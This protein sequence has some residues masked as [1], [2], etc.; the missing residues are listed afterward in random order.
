M[1]NIG[2]LSPGA[3]EY[4]VGEVASSAEDYYAGRGELPGRWVGSLAVELGLSGE[5]D[6]DDF[7]RVLSGQ[8]PGNGVYLTTARGSAARAAVRDERAPVRGELPQFVDTDR[9]AVHLGVSVRYVRQ[10]LVNGE[11]YRTRV[12][13]A[14]DGEPVGVPPAYLLGVKAVGNGQA[15]SD[16]WSVSRGELERFS[17]SRRKV[18]ARPGYDLTLR[19]PKSVSVLWALADDPLRAQ[20]R[21]AHSEAVDEVVRYYET[22]AVFARKGGREQRLVR[23]AGIVA[24][25]FDHRTS[26]AGDP[27]LHT[28][29]VTANMTSV[30]DRDGSWRAIAGKGLYEHAKAAGCLYQAHLR[31]LLGERLGVQFEPVVNGHAEARGVPRAVIDAFSKRRAEITELLAESGNRSAKAA[32][33]ATL[34]TRRAKDYDVDA[35]TLTERWTD[36]ANEFGFGVEQV[37]ACFG[38]DCQR[39]P[40]PASIEAFFEALAGA[41]GMTERSS[42]FR[43]TDV[44]EVCASA[45]GAS[46]TAA[47]LEGIADRFLASDRVLLVDRP[48]RTGR[49]AWNLA[50]TPAERAT[51]ET[52][53][54]QSLDKAVARSVVS[55]SATQRLYTVSALVELEAR[56]LAAANPAERTATALRQ[57]VVDGVISQ[58]GELSGEQQ[59]MVRA[60]CGSGEFIQPV[61]GR[62]GAGKTYALEAV[63]AAHVD[64]GVPILGCAV[65]ATAAAELERQAGFA[66]STGAQAG[67]VARLLLDLS[68]HHSRGLATGTVVVVDEASMLGT[69]DLAR[70]VD[71]V[72]KAG[73]AVR[74][75]G[76]PDQHGSVDVGGVFRRL[77]AD[78]GDRL[79]RL[80]EN[81]RQ[82][83]HGERLA[84]AEYRDGHI[85]DALAR[86]DDADQIVRSPTAGASLDAMTADWYAARLSGHAEPMIAGP[87]SPRQALN[88]RARTLLKANGELTGAPLV[89]AG[90]EFMVGDEV[91][92]RRN[93]RRLNDPNGRG[94]V[95]NGSTGTITGI[96]H[97]RREV[98]VAFEPEGTI[99]IPNEYLSAGRLEQGYARTTYGVQGATHDVV[100]YQPTD[101]SSFEEGYV[102]LTRGRQQTRVYIVDGVQA[103]VDNDEVAHAATEPRQRGIADIAQAL[104]RRRSGHMAAD[105]APDLDAVAQTLAGASLSQLAAR[106]RHLDQLIR[107]APADMSPAIERAQQTIASIRTRQRAWDDVLRAAKAEAPV[108][109]G[110]PVGRD[111]DRAHAALEG[112][113]RAHANMVGR[114]EKAETRQAQRAEW[115]AIHA[116]LIDA[117]ELVTRAET[118][119]EIQVRVA[120]VNNPDP[121]VRDLIGPEP[122]NQRERLAW[123][124]AVEAAAV[125]SA[126]YP[127][128]AGLTSRSAHE[129]LLGAR[130]TTRE[131]GDAY[132][133]TAAAI[134]AVLVGKSVQQSRA[135]DLGLE[136]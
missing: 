126:R 58:R 133:E 75:V 99:R 16:A 20:I 21:Q 76:D 41:H 18:L 121:A 31:R 122:T 111:T 105:A 7:R 104:G 97:D 112:L 70:L 108:P 30:D 44:L 63:V 60:V 73:G 101:V 79:V 91:V 59:M 47:E 103:D 13:N 6:P 39:F 67:T 95:K 34:E 51:A 132:D 117:R 5:V 92:A 82:Q 123:R 24:A 113:D 71:H 118:A 42:T 110:G 43:R 53:A 120:A 88:D 36:E 124:H 93:D 119:R 11:Q 85:A 23:S 83:D 15:G 48:D 50:Q 45:F 109:V 1:L 87:N 17:S 90:R 107:T 128:R 61:S 54:A 32:Q 135:A 74:L 102:A 98:V 89:I 33:V 38:R 29:V 25:A 19:P 84:I 40:E 8:H 116:D 130:P 131:A 27:L 100:R 80:V 64:V 3:T 62:P 57:G 22:N 2:K 35:E 28:H 65:S 86:Y 136:L 81:N 4:Y 134:N 77:C 14:Q 55:R 72:R 26:R 10:L 106:R 69:R 9:A 68:K 115:F 46:A 49:T 52:P 94:F 37:A 78:R 125:Y 129:R 56:L 96:D 114:L 127:H 12:A 66:R